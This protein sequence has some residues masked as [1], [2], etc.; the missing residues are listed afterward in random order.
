VLYHV[1]IGLYQ[2]TRPSQVYDEMQSSVIKLA[3]AGVAAAFVLVTLL[4][5]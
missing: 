1:L 2:S 5:H 4:V 3:L